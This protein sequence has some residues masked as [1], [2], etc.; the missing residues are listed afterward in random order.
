[1]AN[2]QTSHKTMCE[3]LHPPRGIPVCVTDQRLHAA[4]AGTRTA[5]GQRLQLPGYAS[6]PWIY[7]LQ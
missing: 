5:A 2:R 6:H 3:L 4:P 1:M 7:R